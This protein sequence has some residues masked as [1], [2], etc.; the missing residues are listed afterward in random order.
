MSPASG[1]VEHEQFVRGPS[2]GSQ[3]R[4]SGISESEALSRGLGRDG[5]VGALIP[6]L[7]G[8]S[9]DSPRRVILGAGV[10]QHSGR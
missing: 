4:R 7:Q 10:R 2:G 9:L 3:A 8:P 5:A 6:R 1:E